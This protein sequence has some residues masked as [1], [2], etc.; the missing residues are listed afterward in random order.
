MCVATGQNHG[1]NI[2]FQM[3]VDVPSS[4]LVPGFSSIVEIQDSGLIVASFRPAP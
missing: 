2:I 4:E 3:F 1:A